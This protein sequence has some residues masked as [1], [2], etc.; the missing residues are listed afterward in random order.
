M[1]PCIS[2]VL[3]ECKIFL[4]FFKKK[5][6]GFLKYILWF[7]FRVSCKVWM[8]NFMVLKTIILQHLNRAWIFVDM[9][10]LERSNHS[11]M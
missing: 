4:D 8:Q 10:I 5:Y 11:Y 1:I 6:H 7:S 9:P 2:E 3:F